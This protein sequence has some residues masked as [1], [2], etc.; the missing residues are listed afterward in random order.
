MGF[1]S[2]RLRDFLKNPKRKVAQQNRDTYRVMQAHDI[3]ACRECH[4]WETKSETWREEF[5]ILHETWCSFYPSLANMELEASLEDSG[6]FPGS[7]WDPTPVYVGKS[8]YLEAQERTKK[9]V[10]DSKKQAKAF[11]TSF[12]KQ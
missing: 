12:G 1:M 8:E 3:H 6:S 2:K 4:G 9:A 5:P 7:K 10:A 11:W